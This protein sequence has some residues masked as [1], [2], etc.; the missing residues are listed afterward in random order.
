[1]GSLHNAPESVMKPELQELVRHLKAGGRW[2]QL[3]Y[4][5]ARWERE[6]SP[7]FDVWGQMTDGLGTPWCEPYDVPKLL[8]V[9][10]RSS[11]WFC[12]TSFTS[13]LQLV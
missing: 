12:T 8:N 13:G 5:V 6:G 9:R 11:T 1:M 4:P 3:A 10:R 7:P 2:L